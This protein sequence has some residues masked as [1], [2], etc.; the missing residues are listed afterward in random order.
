MNKP[1]TA[2][3]LES[4]ESMLVE[5]GIGDAD[6]IAK[7]TEESQGLGLFAAREPS[8]SQ[9]SNSDATPVSRAMSYPGVRV[10]PRTRGGL[11]RTPPNHE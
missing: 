8:V 9:A 5:S 4:L 6:T 1:L 11:R 10:R 7:G 2:S 3:D